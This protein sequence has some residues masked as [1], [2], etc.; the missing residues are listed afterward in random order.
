[1]GLTYTRDVQ[2]KLVEV[3]PAAQPPSL[4]GLSQHPPFIAAAVST[5]SPTGDD[6]PIRLA[7]RRLS[8]RQVRHWFW[9]HLENQL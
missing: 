3:A 1:M 4:P 5:Y 8:A 9:L 7:Q 6:V 2:V